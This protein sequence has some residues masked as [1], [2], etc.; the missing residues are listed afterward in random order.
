MKNNDKNNDNVIDYDEFREIINQFGMRSLTEDEIRETF[1]NFDVDGNGVITEEEFEE[2][3]NNSEVR[4]KIKVINRNNIEDIAGDKSFVIV[5]KENTFSLLINNLQ[6]NSQ[7]EYIINI[8]SI[9]MQVFNNRTNSL[10]SKYLPIHTLSNTVEQLAVVEILNR[11]CSLKWTYDCT[12]NNYTAEIRSSED[13]IKEWKVF[14]EGKLNYCRASSLKPSRKY[15]FRVKASN[16][17]YSNIVVVQTLLTNPTYPEIWKGKGFPIDCTSIDYDDLDLTIGDVISLTDEVECT[18]IT[19]RGYSFERVVI[20]RIIN[21]VY[22]DGNTIDKMTVSRQISL[23]STSSKR[24]STK[25]LTTT[26]SVFP[27]KSSYV[28][29]IYHIEV[30]QSKLINTPNDCNISNYILSPGNRVY[31]KYY[32]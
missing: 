9:A 27:T 19:N 32:K 29:R 15:E 3:F 22:N 11:E 25:A 20:G 13:N 12:V 5:P 2:W 23:V 31:Y 30:I 17:Y 28:G 18:D 6:P 10:Y 24:R 16:S 1:N 7:Y 26:N 4:Y 21:C 14:Y 8:F